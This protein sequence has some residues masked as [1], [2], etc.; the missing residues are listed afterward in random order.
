MS[1]NYV[2][3]SQ[4]KLSHGDRKMVRVISGKDLRNLVSMREVVEL[5]RQASRPV[6]GPCNA[7]PKE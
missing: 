6:T 1:K 7:T 3:T 4:S 2:V 5:L